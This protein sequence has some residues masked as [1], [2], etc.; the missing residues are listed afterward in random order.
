MNVEIV[1]R[2]ECSIQPE[3]HY[4]I[5]YFPTHCNPSICGVRPLSDPCCA[6]L[7]CQGGS[8]RQPKGAKCQGSAPRTRVVSSTDSVS[9]EN[10]SA[11]DTI[12]LPI[13]DAPNGRGYPWSVPGGPAWDGGGRGNIHQPGT[14]SSWTLLCVEDS[15]HRMCDSPTDRCLL[16]RK[17]IQQATRFAYYEM[18]SMR[19]PKRRYLG[20]TLW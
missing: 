18:P 5:A 15:H 13:T 9:M 8:C 1:S 6:S 4:G 3:I 11:V 10:D 16:R 14:H 19:N 17:L 7:A 2:P 12:S 20:N